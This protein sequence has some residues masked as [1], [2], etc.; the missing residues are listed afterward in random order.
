MCV[1]VGRCREW[2]CDCIAAAHPFSQVVAVLTMLAG[3]SLVG[4]V[5][6]SITSLMAIKNSQS[7]HIAVKKQVRRSLLN[8]QLEAETDVALTSFVAPG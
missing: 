6:S 4:Y 7:T 8:N 2:E 3:V 5:T 1:D